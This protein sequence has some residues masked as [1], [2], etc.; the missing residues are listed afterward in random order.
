VSN[1]SLVGKSGPAAA[2]AAAAAHIT[3]AVS[4]KN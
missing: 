4:K 3:V 1:E 2:A